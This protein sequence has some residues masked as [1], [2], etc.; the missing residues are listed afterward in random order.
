MKCS[1]S[2]CVPIIFQL[3]LLPGLLLINFITGCLKA[4]DHRTNRQ[5]VSRPTTRTSANTRALQSKHHQSH[6]HMSH[7]HQTHH[8]ITG[9]PMSHHMDHMDENLSEKDL[10]SRMNIPSIEITKDTPSESI[11]PIESYSEEEF[12]AA[13]QRQRT[14]G[15]TGVGRGYGTSPVPPQRTRAISDYERSHFGP[16]DHMPNRRA[17]MQRDRERGV[18]WFVALFDYDPLTMSPNPDAAE[19]ELPFQEGQLI[20]VFN[21]FTDKFCHRNYIIFVFRFLVIK[22]PMVSIGVRPTGGSVL[23]R[24]IWFLKYNMTTKQK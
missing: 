14:T 18:R 19:E 8:N 9:Q 10:I 11:N 1:R 4:Y 24:A 2:K 16:S 17:Q 23:C 7:T 6:H 13:M 5:T 3:S 12:D 21:Y 22:M 15:A 20:K